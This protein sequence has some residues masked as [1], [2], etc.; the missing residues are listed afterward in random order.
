M[1]LI[2]IALLR[3]H[4]QPV[5]LST[6]AQRLTI[7]PASANEM[8]RKLAERELIEYQPYK[9]V[10]LTPQGETIAQRV[11]F[12]RRLWEVFLVE[13]LGIGVEDSEEI[14]CHLEHV[15][16]DTLIERLA[17]FLNYPP[18]SPQ[19]EPISYTQHIAATALAQSLT[20]FAVGQAGRITDIIA[21][22]A[23]KSFLQA[24]LIRPGTLLHVLAI[25]PDGVLLVAVGDQHLS[26][27]PA[28]ANHI[29]MERV[30]E[31]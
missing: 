23:V 12:R 6:L 5:P 2:S 19:H 15:T 1:Y 24:Q 21:D 26:L 9:G 4:D 13:K 28:I 27:S 8:C 18:E 3:Q 11:L 14:A 25:A 30:D 7:S 16:S 31:S 17:L 22:E 10:T 20:A 29:V